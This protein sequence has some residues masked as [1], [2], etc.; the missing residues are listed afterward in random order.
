MES[1]NKKILVTGSAGFIGSALVLRLLARGDTVIGIDNHNNYYVHALKEARLARHANHP[2]YT[3][4]IGLGSP[5]YPSIHQ[6][7]A[8]QIVGSTPRADCG[9]QQRASLQNSLTS[10][11]PISAHSKPKLNSSNKR[12]QITDC[13]R[14][15]CGID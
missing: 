14:N 4:R 2:N 15:L 8:S 5:T 9:Q 6:I 10:F 3:R 1:N 7:N 12:P 13:C 11:P